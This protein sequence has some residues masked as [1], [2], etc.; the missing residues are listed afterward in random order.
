[1]I[2]D[3]IRLQLRTAGFV[4]LTFSLYGGLEVD[5][6]LA[7]PNGDRMTI[8]SK[9]IGRYGRGLLRLYGVD[10]AV[11]G[12]HL[13]E[14]R[15]YPGRDA[16]GHGRV[17]VMNHRS[18][19]DVPITL[20]W[21]DSA[22]MSRADLATWPVIGMAARRV[23]TLFVDRSD[24]HSGAAVIATMCGALAAGRGV[25]VYPEGTTYDGDELRPF[26]LGAFR[27]AQRT[28]AEIVPLGVAYGGEGAS[29][30][31]ESFPEHMARISRAKTTRVGLVAGDPILPAASLEDTRD[32]VFEAMQVLVHRARGL[33]TGSRR[34]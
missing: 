14:G 20:A 16:R 27:A 9:W 28:G 33:V 3:A 32:A 30:G 19:L 17:F 24:K 11:D 7:G 29:F 26:R 25:M 8:L 31:D 18:G 4:G 13:S 1:M 22:I 12:P 5:T 15:C 34:S 10:V 2:R 23:G 6:A 21:V